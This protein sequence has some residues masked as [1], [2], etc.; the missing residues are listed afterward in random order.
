MA[1]TVFGGNFEK[2]IL[3]AALKFCRKPV[4][5]K[6]RYLPPILMQHA[7]GKTPFTPLV[8][9]AFLGLRPVYWEL[10]GSSD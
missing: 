5:A 2:L 1:G 10:N 7:P 6:L 4:L 8:R 3:G 9:R